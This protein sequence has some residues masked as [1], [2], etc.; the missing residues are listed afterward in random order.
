MKILRSVRVLAAAATAV[1]LF[2]T[3][4][5]AQTIPQYGE[6]R[7]LGVTSCAGSTCHGSA[8]PWRD[9]TV[10]Q[11]EYI[12]WAQKDR[13]A[14]AYATLRTERSQRIAR[15]L[16]LPNAHE[17]K[18][19]LDCHADNPPP[20]KRGRVF[21]V[22]DGVG[23]EACHG[24]A[25]KWL[26]VHVSGMASHEENIKAGLYPTEEPVARA[27]LCLSCHFGDNNKFVTHRIMGA[28]HPRMSFELDT[29]TAI[30]PAH[31]VVDDDYR[32]RKRVANGV[33]TWAIGQALAIQEI[34]DGLADAKRNRDGIFPELVFFDC[35]ACHHPMSNVRWEPRSGTG[36]GPGIV[37]LNDANLVML[38]VIAGHLDNALG[39]KLKQETIALHKASTQGAE[40]TL[41]AVARLK[42]TT[43]GL[44]Q[45]FAQHQFGA[46]DMQGLLI[47]LVKEGMSG[48]FVDYSAAEQATMAMSA[49]VTSMKRAG[50]ID[51]QRYNA[52]KAALDKCYDAVQKDEEYKPRQFLA[53]LQAFEAT[54][55]KS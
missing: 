45:R 1:A 6:N 43:Q 38:R 12:T 19:C 55:P 36:L 50:V 13:H 34:L 51:D 5:A 11:N 47:G 54:I 30:Q 9:S 4:V 22:S 42:A 49:I 46:N 33:Q 10:L 26:G 7:H 32:K 15:N 23:C 16:G 41:A 52:M 27:K 8:T 14:K 18:V 3:G 25:E 24:G 29:F 2:G 37:R 40:A 21:Q 53:A 17:A 48:E 20:D 28:G 39:Q 35:H 31:Y 44:V